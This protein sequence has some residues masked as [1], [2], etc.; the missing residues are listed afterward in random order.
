MSMTYQEIAKMVEGFGVPF[1]YYMFADNTGQQP[2][3]IC[4]YYPGIDDAYAD[5]SNYQR[6]TQLVI[7]VYTDNKDFAL[8]TTVETGLAAAGLTYQKSETYIDEEKLY[9]VTYESEVC[10]HG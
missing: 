6:I 7:E 1:A 5:N 8:E 2:P 9:M 10:I 3:F 4:F